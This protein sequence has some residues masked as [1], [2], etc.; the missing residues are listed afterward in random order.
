MGRAKKGAAKRLETF[1][2]LG[3]SEGLPFQLTFENDI[4]NVTESSYSDRLI[5]F[6]TIVLVQ[7]SIARYGNALSSVMRRDLN[8][9]YA[10]LLVESGTFVDD[11]MNVMIDKKWMDQPPY[12]DVTKNEEQRQ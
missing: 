11:A 2:K 8:A 5:L 7:I 9:L 3:V 1:Q 4:T 10:R 12:C 6:K